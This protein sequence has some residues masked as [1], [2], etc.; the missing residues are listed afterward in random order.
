M[1]AP[2]DAH[3][4]PG[5]PPTSTDAA[6]TVDTAPVGTPPAGTA[7]PTDNPAA[8]G[9]ASVGTARRSNVAAVRWVGAVLA[10][11]LLVVVLYALVS[12]PTRHI[13]RGDPYP[14]L[15][16]AVLDVAGYF[17]GATLA[18]LCLG[19]LAF[20]VAGS[21]PDSD[22]IIDATV[23]RAHLFVS[24]ATPVWAVVAWLMV[25]VAA[26]DGYGLPLGKLVSSGTLFEA[27][28]ISE[29]AVAWLVVAIFAT[30]VAI[31]VRFFLSWIAHAVLLIPTG[32]AVAALPMAG[33]GAQGPNHDYGT[34]L[35]IVL[36]LAMAV[37]IGYRVAYVAAPTVTPEADRVILER[38]HTWIVGVADVLALISGVILIAFLVPVRYLFTT[39][40]G[41]T[42]VVMVVGLIAATA[43]SVV[44]LRSAS[45]ATRL[46][47]IEMAAVA[48]M[49]AVY[50]CWAIMDT[51]VAPGLLAHPFT[52]WDVFLGYEL[53]GP[54]TAWRLAT[55]WR[56]DFLVGTAAIAAAVL[57][58]IGVLRLRRRGDEWP[59]GRTLSWMLGCLVLVVVTGS[60]VRAYGSAMFSVH[61]AE[62]MALNMFAPVLLVLGAPATLAL[63]A[64][65]TAG[66]R[67]PGPREWLLW[68]LHSKVTRVL[69]NPA[70]ALLLFVL[71][72]YVVYF[73]AIFGTFVRYHWGHVLLTIHFIIVGYLFYWVI[74]GI[75]PGP[76]RIPYLARIGLLF[77][78]MPFHA[79]FGIALMTMSSV[80]GG[81]FYSQLGLPWVTD[82]LHDQWLGGAIAWGASEV[83]VVLVVIAIVTQWAKSD[84]REA[85]R[86]DRHAETYEDSELDDYNKMLEELART[87]R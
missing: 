49:A 33:N 8:A 28:G 86:A 21:R 5:V 56:F 73:T 64:L 38:R 12:G 15:T 20:V 50:V 26:S 27:I 85:R 67:P 22:G 83:P 71:S 76:R 66:S 69:S 60:G 84:R 61:M 14:G 55:F 78:V 44:A 70:V 79:F 18:A 30:I 24:R 45:G 39:T 46:W 3:A 6:A 53:P 17:V 40:F 23:Y 7:V 87:R 1:T 11:G 2:D 81:E 72:L 74:I 13:E 34:S 36:V 31:A 9:A 16:T 63:R 35:V 41:V 54:P 52:A 68:V 47:R 32:I 57:Y 43:S 25:G 65:P 19:A 62:H 51:R 75:D 80:T 29:E 4:D 37:S 59:W 58:G 42:S 77:A 48:V 82:L 10:A